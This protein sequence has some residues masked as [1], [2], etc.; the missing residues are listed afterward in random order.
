MR[1][2]SIPK[3]PEHDDRLVSPLLARQDSLPKMPISPLEELCE[4]Y[5][6]TVLPLLDPHQQAATKTAVATFL[7]SEEGKHLWDVLQQYDAKEVN[8]MEHFYREIYT[9]YDGSNHSLNPN[10]TLSV[11]PALNTGPKRAAAFSYS[12]LHYHQAIKTGKLAA[13]E[14]RAGPLCMRQM[15]WIFGTARIAQPVSVDDLNQNVIDESTHIAV[16]CQGQVF[17]L[18]VLHENG[19]IA[20]DPQLLERRFAEIAAACPA[21]AAASAVGALT[22]AERGVWAPEREKLL[23]SPGNAAALAAVD[24][25]LFVV[26]LDS[27]SGLSA[28]QMELSVLYGVDG[29]FHNRWYDK[30]E[31][32]VC[33]DGQAGVNWEH[34]MLDGHTMMEFVAAAGG[35]YRLEG[36]AVGPLDEATCAVEALPWT[37]DAATQAA[38]AATVA[39]SKQ[40][41]G[42]V[43][44]RILE[45]R[46]FGSSF[47]KSCKCSPDGFVQVRR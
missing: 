26:A 36:A 47:I 6:A 37:A 44:V 4:K 41:S 19:S 22:A 33:E 7:E 45:F 31:L 20:T 28:E 30:W 16:L 29:T 12:A 42:A 34:S 46:G 17:K 39:A 1:Q 10:F 8:Y 25:A 3:E 2:H 5:L 14:T 43:G 21:A 27:V 23:L 35:G 18:T 13:F 15:P 11:D 24:Q 40:K 32:I 9:S 38:I